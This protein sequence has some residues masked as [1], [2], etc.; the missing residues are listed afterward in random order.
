MAD[1]LNFAIETAKQAGKILLDNYGKIKNLEYNT[2][3][4]F[5]TRV[6]QESD[7]L[8]RKRIKENFPDHNIYSEEDADLNKGHE[9]S[10]VIDPLDGTIPYVYGI[11]DHFG[12]CIALVKNKIP[13]V[14]VIY[15]PKRDELY[16]AEKGKGAFCNNKPIKTSLEKTISHAIMG[17]D[18]GKETSY[19]KRAVLGRYMEKVYSPKGISCAVCSGCASVPLC[20]VASGKLH[21]YMAL[22]LE[23][24]D[25]AAAVVINMEAGAKVTNI[26]GKE[27]NILDKSILVSNS[28]LHEKLIDILNK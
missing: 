10:W 28:I 9:F 18:P 14:G 2:R 8:I 13:I 25:M 27:W 21:A 7:E 22:S 5:T 1:Y 17:L 23:P 15:A 11:T 4:H 6:D 24:W 20:L 3:Q 19:F 16:Y 12:V 26:H